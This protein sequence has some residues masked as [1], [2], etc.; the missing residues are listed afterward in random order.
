[1]HVIANVTFQVS[2]FK[3]AILNQGAK[4]PRAATRSFEVY[5]EVLGGK[6]GMRSQAS[7]H[8]LRL[9]P[10]LAT[11]KPD[12]INGIYKNNM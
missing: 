5:Y 7:K 4:A 10:C 9:S 12:T 6:M 8:R 3:S 2:V 1:M 11:A